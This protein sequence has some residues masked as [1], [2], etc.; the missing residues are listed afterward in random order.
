MSPSAPTHPYHTSIRV[1]HNYLPTRIRVGP[2]ETIP[3][4]AVSL[5]TWIS[6][7]A[8]TKKDYGSLVPNTLTHG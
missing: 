7:T 8:M 1:V 6:L 5:P 3:S 4:P 2:G